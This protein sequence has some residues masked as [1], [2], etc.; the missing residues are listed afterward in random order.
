MR[1]ELA[2]LAVAIGAVGCGPS[3]ADF[4][5]VAR[6]LP[7]DGAP[8]VSALLEYERVHGMPAA[9]LE[10]LQGDVLTSI[11]RRTKPAGWDPRGPEWTWAYREGAAIAD[12][13]T[14]GMGEHRWVLFVQTSGAEACCYVLYTPDEHYSKG[15]WFTE[16]W[17]DWAYCCS[18]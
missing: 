17:D 10:D 12:L 5:R 15:G 3:R 18:W 13:G 4:D 2:V 9:S 1:R 8:I 7:E 16:D 6:R 14:C 11:P